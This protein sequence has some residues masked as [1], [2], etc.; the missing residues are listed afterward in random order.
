MK[1]VVSSRQGN[2]DRPTSFRKIMEMS[3]SQEITQIIANS[4]SHEWYLQQFEASAVI[5]FTPN[6]HLKRD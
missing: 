1:Y 3:W 2:V 5:M 6:G 4:Q